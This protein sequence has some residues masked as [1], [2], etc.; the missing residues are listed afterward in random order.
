MTINTTKRILQRIYGHGRGWV[1]I[2]KDF[3]DIASNAALRQSLSRLKKQGTIRRLMQ[4]VYDYPFFSTLLSAPSSPDP[5]AI[6]RA[7]AR[8]NGWT[9][10][11]TGD[12]SLNLVGLSTQVP[13]QYQYF[14]DGP[15]KRYAWQG[16]TLV[17]R[18]RTN[19]ETTVLSPRTALLVQALKRLGESGTDTAVMVALR[20]KFSKQELNL[21]LK[22]ARYATSWV[23]NA[24]KQIAAD[25]MMLHA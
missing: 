25:E 12:L 7:I 13:A 8:A 24:I 15:S 1:F 16:G 11:P 19:K 20:K 2:P 23:Y 6:A 5:D 10:L 17:F 9:I 18:H 14:S 22:E 4:G 21:A 3:L